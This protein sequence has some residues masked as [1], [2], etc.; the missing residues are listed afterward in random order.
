MEFKDYYAA[1]GVEKGATAD[2][3]KKA[4]RKLA[5]RYHPD[6]SKEPDAQ[7]R[8]RQVNEAY[9]VLSD[10]EKRKAYDSL[11]SRYRAGQSFEP[12]PDW[13]GFDFAHGAQGE[14]FSDFFANLFG[15][16]AGRERGPR[17][18]MRGS[19][20]HARI[21]IELADTY[22][23]AQRS[24]VLASPTVDNEGRVTVQERTLNVQIPKGIREGQQIRLAGQGSPGLRGGPAGDL[25]LEVAFAPN[26]RCTIVDK[27]VTQTV[28]LAPWE[29]MLGARIEV[30][31]P[32]GRVEVTVP[33]QSKN[34]ARLRL[35]G[36]GIPA[37]PPGDLY[38]QLELVLPPATDKARQLFE[39]MA[40]EIP[41]N[42][43]DLDNR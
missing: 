34:G 18:P 13:S 19:D 16:R 20:A 5:R 36:R 33:A 12:P 10:A 1:L 17:P 21:E 40:R 11:G 14:D 28:P 42:P 24:I 15:A 38:L 6:V 2:E 43:R 3:I 41:F 32:S 25:Y 23:G 26:R 22:N 9:A 37:D 30:T 35:R 7:E 39:T 31:T 4:Y 8:M 27:D 29:A